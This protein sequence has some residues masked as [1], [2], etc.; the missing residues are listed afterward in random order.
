MNL[1]LLLGRELNSSLNKAVHK[2]EWLS[3]TQPL[4]PILNKMSGG[5]Q[6]GL[7][8]MVKRKISLSRIIYLFS[9]TSS[10]Y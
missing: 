2:D 5:P 6:I 10:L 3:I 9:V 8:A 7:D 1:A 4:L